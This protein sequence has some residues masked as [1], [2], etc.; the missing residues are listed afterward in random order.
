MLVTAEC[1]LKCSRGY[2][3]AI[4][5][6]PFKKKS[7][8]KKKNKL[9]KKQKK[10]SKSKKDA[11]KKAMEK[12]KCFHYN[13]NGHWRRNCLSYLESLKI[14]KNEQPSE[15]MFIIESNLTISFISS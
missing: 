10:E 9:V 4:E 5:W 13:S 7:L 3:L 15:G 6:A 11:L 8:E 12:K 2:V 14:K 1:I